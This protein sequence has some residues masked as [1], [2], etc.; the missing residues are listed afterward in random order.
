MSWS[1]SRPRER[2]LLRRR[3][4]RGLALAPERVRD[5]G[6][7]RP[8]RHDLSEPC[9]DAHER[10]R[11][12]GPDPRQDD[13]GA[14]EPRRVRRADERV[15]DLGVHDRDARDVEDRVLPARRREAFNRFSMTCWA[16]TESITPTS[17]ITRI[18]FEMG[19]SGVESSAIE[20]AWA[21]M[22]SSCFSACASSAAFRA[23]MSVLSSSTLASPPFGSRFST[24]RLD[25]TAAMPSR[26]V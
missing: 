26:R 9:A 11:D 15:R 6:L 1:R 2:E 20:R 3:I 17:G 8:A 22:S 24:H 23:V 5:P 7:E 4:Q 19:M 13:L 14:Q 12:L 18:S 21:R 16:R 25:T 10:L